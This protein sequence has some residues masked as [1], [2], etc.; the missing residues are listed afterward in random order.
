MAAK[1]FSGAIVRIRSILSDWSRMTPISPFESSDRQ[2]RRAVAHAM[3][4]DM[5][6]QLESVRERP[7]WQPAPDWARGAFREPMPQGPTP[8]AQAHDL[9]MRAVA[10]YGS[11]NT[12]P[13]FMGWVQGGGSDVGMLAEML[14]AGLNANCGGRDHMPLAVERQITLWMAELFGFPQTAEG[15]FVTGASIANF[16]AILIARTR[17]LGAEVRTAGLQTDGLKLTAYASSAAHGCVGR[18]M[19]MAGLGADALRLVPADAD[20]RLDVMALGRAIAADRAAG[21]TPFLVVGAAGTV[22]VGAIDDLGALADLCAAEGLWFHVDGALGALGVLSPQIAPLLEGVQRADSIAFDFH[23]WAQ[24]PYDAGYLLVRDGAAQKTTFAHAAAYLQRDGRGIGGGD[25][26]PCD[27]GPDLSRGF[28]ALKVWFTLKV[29]GAAA[30]GEVISRSCALARQLAARVRA[31]P[32]LELLA[33]VGLNIV[34]F[35]YRGQNADA[36]NAEIVA[37]LQEGGRVAPSQTRVNG[38][39]AIRAAFLNHRTGPAEVDALV[40]AVL[41]LGRAIAQGPTP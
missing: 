12:H 30:L 20:H 14:A 10:P 27:Y 18:G 36:L 15:L 19:D 26:W 28:R 29:F 40:R 4:D 37:R 23:K 8:L 22:D 32:E 1:Q 24:A 6:D 21:F 17:T 13:G 38:A 39:G 25:W 41:D 35:R 3:L 31:E 9:F 11:G 5:L 16:M 7:L 33:P 34:C 2:D